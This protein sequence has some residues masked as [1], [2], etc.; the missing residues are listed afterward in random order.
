MA[1]TFSKKGLRRDLNFS[2]ILNP[3]ESLNNLL[4]GLVQEEGESFI[5]EDL[6]A[7]RDIR[8][9]NIENTDF[10]GI[11]NIATQFVD[12]NN[13]LR[14][15]EP[16]ITVKN[17]IDQI[18]FTSGEPRLFGGDGL[19][20]RYYED[21]QVNSTAVNAED[22]FSGEAVGEEI[23]WENGNFDYV[24][25]P[26][27]LST[28]GGISFTGFFKPTKIGF[29]TLPF[30]TSAFFT[31]EFDDGSGNYELLFRKSQLEYSFTVNAANSGQDTIV[32]QNS[33][34]AKNLLLG[35]RVINTSIAQ[36]NDP[37]NPVTIISINQ[38]TGA[39]ELSENLSANVADSTAFTFEFQ[40][41]VE[42]NSRSLSLGSLQEY[43]PYA[44]RFQYWIPNEEFVTP[45]MVRTLN[46][47]I[48]PPAEQT[49][50]LNY[51][52]LYSENYP[53]N[54]ST[55]STDYGDFSLFYDNRLSVAGGVVGGFGSYAEYQKIESLGPLNITYEPP[56][57]FSAI[58]KGSKTVSYSQTSKILPIS[59]TD[60]IEI[61]NYVFGTGIGAGT[62][63]SGISIN[64]F[65]FI[66]TDTL[67]A[68]SSD[69]VVFVDH[70]GLGAFDTGA[71]W[72]SGNNTITGL[73][74]NTTDNVRE[75][76][77]IVLNGSPQYNI[78][79]SVGSTSVTAS[80]TFTTSSGSDINGIAFFYRANGLYNDSLL[81]YC[82]NVFSAE[83]TTSASAGTDILTVDT[84][85]NLQAGQVVQF[86]SRIPEGTTI[87]S[88]TP[89]GADFDI[90]LSNN[91]TD[92]IISGQLITFAPA[93]TTESKELCFPPTDTS[94]PF[95]ATVL[96]LE[97]T[98]TRPSMTID[99]ATGTGELK[100]VGLSADNITVQTAS[101][102]DTY[103]R[104]I[105]IT[106]GAG[107]TYKV[108]GSTT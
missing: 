105:T 1:R 52:Y 25:I 54:P 40:F 83:T 73:S 39:I 53:L 17:R 50:D 87:V 24:G 18:R 36:F 60:P 98:N 15:Y 67:T 2:D 29:W 101:E 55:T 82:E 84:N 35:D 8:S 23:F 31:V 44:I 41:G 57:S 16:I 99:P 27:V 22:I 9:S 66:D 49:I 46:I 37:E 107:N 14:V 85:A 104:T 10:L 81:T 12:E 64:E 30:N 5:S 3:R 45:D 20:A 38:T 94:P 56:T 33:D 69:T 80:N 68:Q 96:G 13:Q 19:T 74:T 89:N 59:I 4:N 100:F 72:T 6:N 106:D 91:L 28:F 48:T 47:N 26:E 92:T 63:V 21:S 78:V 7:I 70:R 95:N 75:G 108:L 86:G 97:T 43:E 71:S 65:V 93:G 90:E 102:S 61:G 51:K 77:V 88:I 58:Q 42:N 62:R 34:N 11:A 76:D 32:L 103:N 79:Q